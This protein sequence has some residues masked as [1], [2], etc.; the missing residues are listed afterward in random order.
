MGRTAA[1]VW[2]VVM[3]GFLYDASSETARPFKV[4]AQTAP[5]HQIELSWEAV[6]GQR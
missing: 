3:H 5:N 4:R 6:I 1:M 2:N